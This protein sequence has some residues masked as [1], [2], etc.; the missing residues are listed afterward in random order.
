[1]SFGKCLRLRQSFSFGK[2]LSLC[3]S[4][5]LRLRVGICLRLCRCQCLSLC[6]GCGFGL[7]IGLGLLFGGSQSLG[8]QLGALSLFSDGSALGCF[9]LGAGLVNRLGQARLHCTDALDRALGLADRCAHALGH[10]GCQAQRL[11]AKGFGQAVDG[12]AL[13]DQLG[14]GPD[15]SGQHGQRGR[16]SGRSQP[17]AA[18]VQVC[19]QIPLDR[20]QGFDL[21]LELG[22]ARLAL[23]LQLRS[24]GTQRRRSFS[25]RVV[26]APALLGVCGRQGAVGL[27][28]QIRQLLAKVSGL[29]SVLRQLFCQCRRVAQ[30]RRAREQ[31]LG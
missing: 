21:R 2:C 5:S 12:L 25:Q 1:M 11:L 17:P 4:L 19:L 7:R 13:F 6:Q 28:Q 30:E 14:H 18:L 27:C 20:I 24:A 8:F 29:C 10:V 22:S 23:A 16:Q 26:P 15:T 9:G 3:Q 31:R